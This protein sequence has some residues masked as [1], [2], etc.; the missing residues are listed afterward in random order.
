MMWSTIPFKDLDMLVLP[1]EIMLFSST[2]LFA[3]ALS[4]QKFKTMEF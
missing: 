1:L 3:F 2:F 4:E